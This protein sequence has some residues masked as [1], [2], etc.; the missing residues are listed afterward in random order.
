MTTRK[1]AVRVNKVLIAEEAWRL[2]YLK[3]AAFTTVTL[4]KRLNMPPNRHFRQYLN[5][6]AASGLLAVTRQLCNDGHYRK[7][8][9]A[10]QTKS[11]FTFDEK[12]KIA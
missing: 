9:Y 5:S 2:A 3:E 8:F 1:K 4:A 12:E 10:Q 7:Y 11:M 6:L